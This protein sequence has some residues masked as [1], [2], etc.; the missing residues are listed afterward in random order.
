MNRKN[1]DRRFLNEALI[2]QLNHGI[3]QFGNALSSVF[4]TVYLWRLT[5]DLWING[6]FNLIMLLSGPIATIYIG[7]VAKLRDRLLAYRL[8][9]F[10][11]AVL[12]LGI[13]I[14]QERMVDYFVVFALLRGVSNAFYWLGHFTLISEVTN[15]ENRHQYLG[16]N[17]IITNVATLAGPAVAGLLIGSFEGLQGY[18]YIYLLAFL[19]FF[20]ASLVSL[21]LKKSPSHHKAYYLKYTGQM[22][23]KYSIFGRSLAGWFVMGLPQ[24]IMSYMPTIILYQAVPKESFVGWMNMAFTGIMILSGYFLAKKA[25][26]E[27]T[28]LFL[29]LSAWGFLVSSVPLLWGISLVT[30]ILFMSVYSFV[31][32]LQTNVFTAHYYRMSGELPL[33]PHYRIEAVVVRETSINMGRAMGVV[34]FMLASTYLGTAWMP[35]ILVLVMAT[36]LAVNQLIDLREA[37]N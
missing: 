36:Q 13:L 14:V 29:W 11:T 34:L 8:G 15:N 4:L 22:M 24:G 25:K 9:I 2:T 17:Q 37:N 21:K 7:K 3:F 23:R 6:A 12:Y 27:Q 20:L 32:P 30:V 18:M 10:L 5:N 1:Y 19:M 26:A 16:W 35:W 33:G 31:K 28:R